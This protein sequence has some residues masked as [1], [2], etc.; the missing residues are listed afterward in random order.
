MGSYG[1]YPF[2]VQLLGPTIYTLRF[3]HVVV[4]TKS[5]F[6]FVAVHPLYRYYYNML[7]QSPVGAHL[8]SCHFLASSHSLMDIVLFSNIYNILRKSFSYG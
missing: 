1:I 7:I 8:C 6:F 3:V 4:S 5:T 2:F